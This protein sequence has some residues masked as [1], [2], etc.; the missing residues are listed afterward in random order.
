MGE[1]G[2]RIWSDRCRKL[3]REDGKDTQICPSERDAEPSKHAVEQ[4]LNAALSRG[5]PGWAAGSSYGPASPD[6]PFS[7]FPPCPKCQASVGSE[8]ALGGLLYFL[9]LALPS[10][11]LPS[12]PVC[13]LCPGSPLASI[14]SPLPLGLQQLLK[15]H[16]SAGGEQAVGAPRLAVPPLTS[17]PP[18]ELSALFTFPALSLSCRH[19]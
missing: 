5:R 2:G 6:S 1:A 18:L 10:V 9:L 12:P 17:P 11:T 3:G 14:S 19:P 8:Q 4:T 13:P 7:N 16:I 15:C